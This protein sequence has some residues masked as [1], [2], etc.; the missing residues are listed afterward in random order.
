MKRLF[1]EKHVESMLKF[2]KKHLPEYI[3][4]DVGE[5]E[6][7]ERVLTLMDADQN[8][9]LLAYFEDLDESTIMKE[10]KKMGFESNVSAREKRDILNRTIV[11]KLTSQ[12]V[13]N[14]TLL[15][16]EKLFNAIDRSLGKKRIFDGFT[17]YKELINK[18]TNKES[19][20]IQREE[21]QRLSTGRKRSRTDMFG[22]SLPKR[23]P[24]IGLYD[25]NEISYQL[26]TRNLPLPEASEDIKDDVA[27]P[28]NVEVK[29]RRTVSIYDLVD[30]SN[31]ILRKKKILC[32]DPSGPINYYGDNKFRLVSIRKE[33]QAMPEV[34]FKLDTYKKFDLRSFIEDVLYLRNKIEPPRESRF[35]TPE[36]FRKYAKGSRHFFR[37]YIV[38]TITRLLMN[39]DKYLTYSDAKMISREIRE[40][41]QMKDYEYFYNLY[42]RSADFIPN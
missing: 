5:R 20:R 26:S 31:V 23:T 27:P 12:I 35:K 21:E 9:L 25:E 33:V 18:A 6:Q 42:F 41:L 30:D 29:G 1:G 8:R 19:K 17:G 4:S 22:R 34:K 28:A 11:T 40:N 13:R 2:M 16:Q 37:F 24:F 14:I 15:D 39:Q 3:R 10:L 38:K 36:E 7:A 32:L